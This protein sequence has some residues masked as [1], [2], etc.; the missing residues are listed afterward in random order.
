MEDNMSKKKQDSLFWGLIL[1]VVGTLILLD[2]LG[3]EI[4]V[5]GIIGDYWPMILIGIGIKSIWQYFG[6]K[7]REEQQP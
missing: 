5:W 3:V 7:R 6:N 2:N 1:L 4:D